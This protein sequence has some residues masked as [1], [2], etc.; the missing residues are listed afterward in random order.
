VAKLENVDLRM[1]AFAPEVKAK[2]KK[3]ILEVDPQSQ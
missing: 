1:S 2:R 3:D